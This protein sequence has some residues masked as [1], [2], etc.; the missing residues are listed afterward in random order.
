MEWPADQAFRIA[1]RIHHRVGGHGL[2]GKRAYKPGEPAPATGEYAQLGVLGAATGVRVIMLAGQRLPDA[3]RDFTWI[4]VADGGMLRSPSEDAG[5]NE[6]T[7]SRMLAEAEAYR[8]L[9]ATAQTAAARN[10]LTA[11]AEGFAAF[12]A[13]LE[14][15]NRQQ[16]GDQANAAAKLECC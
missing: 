4:L 13:Q 3:G 5:F 9:A 12:A 16:P 14:A 11:L 10:E 6:M 8:Q 2:S 1:L 15:K 7:A